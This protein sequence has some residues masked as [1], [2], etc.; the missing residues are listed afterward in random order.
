MA[1]N[2][3]VISRGW[4]MLSGFCDTTFKDDYSD[5][6]LNALIVRIDDKNYLC[7]EDPDD[8]Y[9]SHSE[10][11]VTDKECTNT[12]PPQRVMV[13]HYDRGRSGYKDC[14]IEV[15]N[16]DFE[17]ILRVGTDNYDDYYP[18]AVWEW[19]PEN[20]P[21]NKG[22]HKLEY[23]MPGE[24]SMKIHQIINGIGQPID[25]G[26]MLDIIDSYYRAAYHKG[27]CDMAAAV[28]EAIGDLD[29]YGKEWSRVGDYVSA[30]ERVI[31]KI[32]LIDPDYAKEA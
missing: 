24:L 17:L 23:K 1:K 31:E 29:D 15:Y 26:R 25:L 18:M 12:F 28:K 32:Q 20:L 27:R 10:F 11:D 16:P 22:V 3:D 19:H 7:Y 6:E 4:H 14:G 21:I 8:G 5:E 9:R 2:Y 30:V 13:M